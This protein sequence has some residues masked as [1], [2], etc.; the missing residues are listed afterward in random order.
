[1]FELLN[2]RVHW[3]SDSKWISFKSVDK[4]E[5]VDKKDDTQN[6]ESVLLR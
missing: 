5:W 6:S 2:S 3:L 4:K 1:M